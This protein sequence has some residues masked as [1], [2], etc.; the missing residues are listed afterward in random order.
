VGYG[1]KSVSS[2][3]SGGSAIEAE[4]KELKDKKMKLAYTLFDMTMK[5]CA[6]V[7]SYVYI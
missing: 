7:Y 3:E 5:V 2:E 1:L 4:S 6:C